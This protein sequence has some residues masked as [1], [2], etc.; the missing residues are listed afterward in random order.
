[1]LIV[2]ADPGIPESV[3]EHR[4]AH[5]YYLIEPRALIR[6]VLLSNPLRNTWKGLLEGRKTVVNYKGGE[7]RVATARVGGVSLGTASA[8]I[9]YGM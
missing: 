1:M 3:F 8:D 5:H 7:D 6:S 4:H 9:I 2:F